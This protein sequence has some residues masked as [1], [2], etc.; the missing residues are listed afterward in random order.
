MPGRRFFSAGVLWLPKNALKLTVYNQKSDRAK[1]FTPDK[2]LK[3]VIMRR[4]GIRPA[5]GKY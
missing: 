1:D 3:I 5:K 2:N 4:L